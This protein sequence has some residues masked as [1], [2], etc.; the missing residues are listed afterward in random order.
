M[1]KT[2]SKQQK[3]NAAHREATRIASDR[4]ATKRFIQRYA[5]ADDLVAVE[6]MVQSQRAA[7]KER[8]AEAIRPLDLYAGVIGHSSDDQPPRGF[9][10]IESADVIT[11]S[12]EGKFLVK[13]PDRSKLDPFSFDWHQRETLASDH[14]DALWQWESKLPR[15]H[16]ESRIFRAYPVEK[17][18]EIEAELEKQFGYQPRFKVRYSAAAL[19]RRENEFFSPFSEEPIIRWEGAGRGYWPTQQTEVVS[20]NLSLVEDQP[21]EEGHPPLLETEVLRPAYEALSKEDKPVYVP[22]DQ[23]PVLKPRKYQA[24]KVTRRTQ[25]DG[26]ERE[27]RKPAGQYRGLNRTEAYKAY[28]KDHPHANL[29]NIELEEI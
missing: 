24:I 26:T 2:I 13:T 9:D 22:T 14:L 18:A 7:L 29:D 27:Y 23:A 1:A 4:S 5:T 25:K 17:R 28:R 11:A 21:W 15:L 10:V 3:W 20:G 16:T 8:E 6:K 12:F 19:T